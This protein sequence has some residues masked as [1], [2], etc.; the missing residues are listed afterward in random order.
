MSKRIRFINPFGT[1]AYDALIHETLSHYCMDGTELDIVHLDACPAD[2]DYFYPKHFAE[3]AIHE[4]VLQAEEDGCDAVISG[5][6]YDPGVLVARELTDMPVIGP[7]E[8]SLQLL[9]YHGRSAVIITDHVKACAWMK[10]NA[11]LYGATDLIAG[12]DVIEWYVRDMINDTESVA[13]DVVRV[14]RDAVARTGAEAVILNCTIISASYQKYLMN[15]GEPAEVP[16]LNPNLMALMMA[17]TTAHM[18]QRGV[19]NLSR[20]GF[21]GKPHNAHY[22]RTSRDVRKAMR[23]ATD[24][25]AEN[26]K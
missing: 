14:A 3:L 5:C 12:Y 11:R 8:A 10:D 9:G 1:T 7:M 20:K 6:C 24:L 23:A 16:V 18:H 22:A 15:G 21:Y 4:A 19:L 26:F 13:H 25:I 17:E 2:I